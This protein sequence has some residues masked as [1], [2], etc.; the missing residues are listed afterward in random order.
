M[1]GIFALLNAD[2]KLNNKDI[3]TAFY[4]AQSRGPELSRSISPCIA[5]NIGFHRLAINGLNADSDQPMLNEEIL[6]ICNGEIYNYN[7][8][9]KLLPDNTAKSDSDC[10]VI[11][12]M[13]KKFGI[14]YTL[15]NLD[16]VFAFVLIDLGKNMLFVARDP[17]GVRPLYHM[18]FTYNTKLKN[19]I[20]LNAFTS[21]MKQMTP[22][23]NKLYESLTINE[24]PP[25]TKQ[26]T[27]G[28]YSSYSLHE[29]SWHFMK[30]DRFSTHGFLEHRIS[31]YDNLLQ[32]IHERLVNAVKKRVV[33]TTDRPVACLLSG[34]LDSSLVTS[35]VS[36]YVPELETYSIG[37]K[38]SE[39]LKY[40]KLVAD[41]LGTKHTE[42]IVDENHFFN[43]IPE[44]IKKIESF[45]T[46]TVRASVGNYLVSKWIKEH[47]DSKVIFNGD[48]SDEVSGGYMYFH[49][50][51]NPTEFD[52]DCRRLLNEIHFFDVLRSDRSISTNGL[53]PRTPFLDRSFVQFY[54]SIPKEIRCHN[55]HGKCEKYLIREAFND[56]SW[57]PEAVLF[58]TKEAFS[59]G[60]SSQTK[61]WFEI[62]N[63][64][65]SVI[66]PKDES[67]ALMTAYKYEHMPPETL[68]QLYY[69]TTFDKLYPNMATTIPH[70]WMPNFVD[71]KDSSARTLDVYNQ[72][73]ST[74]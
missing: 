56:G 15:N 50:A 1:C 35:I 26:F 10:E 37:L 40:A 12:H 72:Q 39:D 5:C 73:M 69:R 34:G 71:A 57:L 6:L 11:I 66:W 61:S 9:Y 55:L 42:I 46:T 63:E 62:I 59:D 67:D 18:E 48:G 2:S 64:K 3:E 13:Y 43:A 33:G 14:D 45:D 44:V 41:F 24:K 17:Y 68:E 36:R 51:P 38:G 28:T 52:L 32:E 16:G 4:Q 74:L 31:N 53:E 20:S 7:E 47:S 54:L 27:P 19:N 49:A 25:V 8:L 30:S 23:N 29:G 60:V 65:V 58:R 21:E 70:F 22:M